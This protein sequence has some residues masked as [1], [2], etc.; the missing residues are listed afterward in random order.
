MVLVLLKPE[1]PEMIWLWN[2]LENHP[3]NEGLDN[4][5]TALNKGESWQYMGT[6]EHKGKY[7]S[8]FRHRVHIKTQNTEWLK[9]THE[10][11]KDS[12]LPK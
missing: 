7:V 5:T 3:L 1:S 6:F 11:N 9:V 4:P 2:W 12:I 8:E 10:V